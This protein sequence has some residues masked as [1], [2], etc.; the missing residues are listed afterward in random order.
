MQSVSITI[1]SSRLIE[2]INL[3]YWRFYNYK[4]IIQVC[5]ESELYPLYA[6]CI[7]AMTENSII[8]GKFNIFLAVEKLKNIN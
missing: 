7:A 5:M 3:E 6:V 8:R 1:E 2:S 4:E